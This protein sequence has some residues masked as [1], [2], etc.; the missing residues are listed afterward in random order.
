[1]FA[2]VP[3]PFV[4]RE[5]PPAAELLAPPLD[6]V[7]ADNLVAG[8]RA[9]EPLLVVPA[10]GAV[11]VDG[12]GL[13]PIAWADHPD[14]LRA[15][16]DACPGSPVPDAHPRLERA[17]Q[18]LAALWARPASTVTALPALER[19]FALAAGAALASIGHVVWSSREDTDPLL[20]LERLNTLQ[21]VAR[22][23][24]AVLRVVLPLGGRYFALRNHGL[25]GAVPDVP[26]LPVP[27]EIVGG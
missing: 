19:C 2:G 1:M 4:E 14:D 23:A 13:F 7:L 8:H 6:A 24:D 3:A 10:D 22:P 21:A 15:W 26:W 11:L 5:L 16:I 12:D 17:R 27:L 25:L 20:T 9:G 18:V